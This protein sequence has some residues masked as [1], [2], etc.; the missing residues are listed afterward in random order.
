V[1]SL[2]ALPGKPWCCLPALRYRA[3]GVTAWRTCLGRKAAERGW[4]HVCM[5]QFESRA[6]SCLLLS[7]LDGE[8]EDIRRVHTYLNRSTAASTLLVALAFPSAPPCPTAPFGCQGGRAH[9]QHRC[10]RWVRQK[11]LAARSRV[12]ELAAS[13]WILASPCVRLRSGSRRWL[14]RGQGVSLGE[15][16]CLHLRVWNDGALLIRVVWPF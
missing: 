4:A 16:N 13:A 2:L 9:V 5:Q 6:F 8:G 1:D 7:R 14:G 10:A 11:A 15:R 12:R 3:L